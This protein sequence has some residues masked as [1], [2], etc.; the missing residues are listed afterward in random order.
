MDGVRKGLRQQFQHGLVDQDEPCLG[1]RAGSMCCDVL[2]YCL[3]ARSCHDPKRP[4]HYQSRSIDP[5][6]YTGY[7]VE[8]ETHKWMNGVVEKTESLERK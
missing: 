5:T 8:P 1:Y 3:A 4:F 7:K 6:G 2:E